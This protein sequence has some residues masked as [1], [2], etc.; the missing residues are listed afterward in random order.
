MEKHYCLMDL[1]QGKSST[2]KQVAKFNTRQEAEDYA[3][4]FG[5]TN[6]WVAT[7]VYMKF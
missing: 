1:D 2:G 4:K 7:A 3:E 6:Y 5:V